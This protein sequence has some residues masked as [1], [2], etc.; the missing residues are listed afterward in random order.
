MT[1]SIGGIGVTV[2]ASSRKD[3]NSSRRTQTNTAEYADALSEKLL[4]EIVLNQVGRPD[5]RPDG[6]RHSEFVGTPMSYLLENDISDE[7]GRASGGDPGLSSLSGAMDDESVNSKGSARDG[8]SMGDESSHFTLASNGITSSLFENNSTAMSRDIRSP[9]ISK[10]RRPGAKNK[11]KQ[12][13]LQSMGRNNHSIPPLQKSAGLLS[14]S[15]DRLPGAPDQL[16]NYSKYMKTAPAWKPENDSLFAPAPKSVYKEG[17]E[18]KIADLKSKYFKIDKNDDNIM[19]I[20]LL[21]AEDGD[22]NGDMVVLLQPNQSHSSKHAAD[23]AINL[24]LAPLS[25]LEDVRVDTVILEPAL[26]PFS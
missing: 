16:N 3:I 5:S 4:S 15:L 24:D 9:I 22:S 6:S 13:H 26:A 8:G 19:P 25:R 1:N 10:N 23:L 2:R 7:L 11:Q 12:G 14:K 18:R 21:C 20:V 17:T